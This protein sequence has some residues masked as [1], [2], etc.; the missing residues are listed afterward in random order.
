MTK[1]PWRCQPAAGMPAVPLHGGGPF[2][3]HHDG[4][5]GDGDTPWRD[6]NC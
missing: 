5:S 6:D 4:G 2:P 1:E 3:V